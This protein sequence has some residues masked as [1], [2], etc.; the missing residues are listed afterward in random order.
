MERVVFLD[1]DGT[2][3]REVHYLHKKEDLQIIPDVPK[4]LVLLKEAG[5]KL[6]VVTNQS[7]VAR[8]YYTE[9]EVEELHGYMNAILQKE[10]AAID[11]FYYCPHHPVKGAGAYKTECG[12]R[13]PGIGMF[14]MAEKQ[15]SVD[16]EH[17]FM[18]GDKSLDAEAGKNYGLTSILVGTGYGKEIHDR[19]IEAGVVPV[20]D[21]YSDTLLDAARWIVKKGQAEKR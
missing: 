6:V 8:G 1:R 20:Y 12:C 15:F 10:G 3:N 16:R 14:E 11:G 7:G 21:Y 19:D 5:Y 4:A 13:K 18:I 9:K 2:L 17:S